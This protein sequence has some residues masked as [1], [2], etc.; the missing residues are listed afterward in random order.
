MAVS[1]SAEE[2]YLQFDVGILSC[3]THVLMR[4]KDQSSLLFVL[5]RA[6]NLAP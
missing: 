6:A 5:L 1:L 4:N 2:V 3:E